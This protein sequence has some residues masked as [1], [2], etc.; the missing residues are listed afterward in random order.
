MTFRLFF[1][2]VA[3]TLAASILRQLAP[4]SKSSHPPLA[5]SSISYLKLTA[6]RSGEQPAGIRPPYPGVLHRPGCS[7]IP[8][9]V[10]Y[11]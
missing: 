2:S 6:T 3:S 11:R 1:F 7:C 10:G 5:P 8:P 9:A 4:V